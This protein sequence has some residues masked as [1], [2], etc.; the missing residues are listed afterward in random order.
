[1]KKTYN[2]ITE[3]NNLP[4]SL[5]CSEWSV[6]VEVY[7]ETTGNPAQLPNIEVRSYRFLDRPAA[8]NFIKSFEHHKNKLD[9]YGYTI[10]HG[11]SQPN[12]S[13]DFNTILSSI[14]EV[15]TEKNKRYG[16]SALNPI[17]VFAG[18]SKVG[19]RADDKVSRIK[20]SDVLRKNDVADLIGYL[21]LMCQENGWHDFKDQID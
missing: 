1:M 15:L 14:G 12:Q 8:K 5:I 20:N 3:V 19:Q 7:F 16:G 17:S 6:L 13:N 10:V 9:S 21:V 18:K 11:K 2:L 4:S